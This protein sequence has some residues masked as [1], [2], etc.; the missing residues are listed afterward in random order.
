MLKKNSTEYRILARFVHRISGKPDKGPAI[1]D[2]NAPPF[3]DGIK[4]ISPRRLLRRITLSLAAR[5]PTKKEYA[6]VDKH[7]LKAIDAI[8]DQVM[9]EDAFYDRLQEA[10][11][12]IL[13]TKGYDGSAEGA[14]SYE[15]FKNRLWYQDHSP[16]KNLSKEKKLKYSHPKMIAYTKLVSP[17]PRG[18]AS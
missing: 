13:L 17:V 6:T 5:L 12:D 1:A 4:M 3:F 9:K 18:N 14:L 10:F 7:G 2:Y 11:N 16:N 8:L 15:H